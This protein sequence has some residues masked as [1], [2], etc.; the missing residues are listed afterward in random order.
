MRSGSRVSGRSLRRGPEGLRGCVPGVTWPRHPRAGT[1]GLSRP[2]PRGACWGPGR[3][4]VRVRCQP[5]PPPGRWTARPGVTL[6]P[7]SPT[8]SAAMAPSCPAGE[9]GAGK[10][11]L[12]GLAL[13][14]S[15]VTQVCG[16]AH[17]TSG[18]AATT[19]GSPL[20]YPSM[21]GRGSHPSCSACVKGERGRPEAPS[22][23]CRPTLWALESNPGGASSWKERSRDEGFV[24]DAQ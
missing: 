23:S 2:T 4:C 8:L 3:G 1:P 21:L 7:P 24:R 15:A 5:R 13:K 10:V 14:M 11:F 12:A 16:A 20:L 6:S 18:G 9:G 17:P 19:P 22:P